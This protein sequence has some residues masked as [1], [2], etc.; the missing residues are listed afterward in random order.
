MPVES[1]KLILFYMYVQVE[2]ILPVDLT[3]FLSSL[4]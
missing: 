4:I 2:S 1:E 3:N